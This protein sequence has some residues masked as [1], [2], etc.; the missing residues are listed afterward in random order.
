MH[1][2]YSST[3][4][5]S[6]FNLI[7]TF[8]F[9][10]FWFHQD[11]EITKNLFSFT[12]NIFGK[13]KLSC[14]CLN[15]AKLYHG[16]KTGNPG[17]AVSLH[18]AHSDSQSEHWIRCILMP[19]RRAC[20]IIKFHAVFH[21]DSSFLTKD[22]QLGCKELPE[23]IQDPTFH[24]YWKLNLISKATIPHLVTQL[25]MMPRYYVHN[26]LWA[27]L[28]CTPTGTGTET[29]NHNIMKWKILVTVWKT[30][31]WKSKLSSPLAIWNW[32]LVQKIWILMS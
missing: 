17:R 13:T 10:I 1:Y 19:P 14:T 4:S 8:G 9:P 20:H 21:N 7:D 22:S 27:L 2:W 16:N 5:F 31:Q 18:L 28:H 6:V 30:N 25:F 3:F 29:Q 26:R 32:F 11:R 23:G 12:D 15:L 24:H